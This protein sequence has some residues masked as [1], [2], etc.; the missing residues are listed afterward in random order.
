MNLF[1][2][3]TFLGISIFSWYSNAKSIKDANV[4][5][6]AELPTTNG[7]GVN[8]GA[9]PR[10]ADDEII[11]ITDLGGTCRAPK[12][13]A[14]WKCIGDLV[15]GCIDHGIQKWRCWKQCYYDRSTWC[16]TQVIVLLVPEIGVPTVH[17]R[18]TGAG[19]GTGTPKELGAYCAEHGFGLAKC[20]GMCHSNSAGR[21]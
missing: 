4:T 8:S 17:S 12:S 6:E 1:W 15:Y 7:T 19:T 20:V 21:Q 18:C 3:A 11:E 5:S 2:I 10:A 16:Y 9:N 13:W 14:K